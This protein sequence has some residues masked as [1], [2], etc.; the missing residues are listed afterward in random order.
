[1][2]IVTG[3]I[4]N[5]KGWRTLIIILLVEDVSLSRVLAPM[6]FPGLFF[7]MKLTT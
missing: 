2:Q 7:A 3:H 6:L 4:H 1:M 5:K